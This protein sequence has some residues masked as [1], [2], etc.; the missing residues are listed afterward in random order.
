MVKWC[1]AVITPAVLAAIWRIFHC[2]VFYIKFRRYCQIPASG[3]DMLDTS[4][5]GVGTDLEHK[6]ILGKYIRVLGM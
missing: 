4:H 3:A 6:C 1:F 2:L 5:G